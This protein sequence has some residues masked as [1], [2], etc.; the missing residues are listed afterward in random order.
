MSANRKTTVGV[1]FGGRSVEHDVSIV[2]GHQIMRAFDYNRYD[3][4]PLY[5]DRDGKWFTG[6]PLMDLKNYTLNLTDLM[7]VQEVILSP[8]TKDHGIIINPGAGL[9]SKSRTLRLDY[10]FPAI[11][12][13]HG[14]DGTLQG[15]FEL[16]DIPYVGC[17]VVA[18]AI[19]NNKIMSK[20]V[21]RQYQIP[22]L[23]GVSFTRDEW[24]QDD[25]RVLQQVIQH[26]GLPVFVKPATLGSSIGIS[27]ATDEKSLRSSLTMAF[28]FDSQVL[29]EVAAQNCIEINC[30]VMGNGYTVRPSVLERPISYDEFLTYEEKYLQGGGGMKGAERII[31]APISTELT[32]AIQGAAVTAFQ[33]I[34]GSGIARLDFLLNE[35]SG[36]FYLNEINTLPGSLSFYLWQ[37]E[38]LTPRQVVEELLRIAESVNRNKRG[39]TYN[40]QTSLVELTAQRGLKGTKGK[41]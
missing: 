41:L 9:F 19:A 16:A 3:V 34:H 7:G 15:L 27:K 32:E 20:I 38:G 35:S 18:S 24:D 39:N 22:V 25:N 10:V 1:V 36:E 23:D 31:P 12:G 4:V 33:A 30:A 17:G 14:E 13:S 6:V 5:I 40:Y 2:T 26:L 21:C 28:N 8:S 37:A 11:H 29:V